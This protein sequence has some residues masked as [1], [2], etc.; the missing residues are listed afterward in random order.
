[1]NV[2]ITGHRSGLGLALSN[3]LTHQ[4]HKVRGF[5]KSTG[6]NILSYESRLPMIAETKFTY[7][8]VFNNAYA[9]P[10]QIDVLYDY[11]EVWQ[12]K[13]DKTIV[14]ISCTLDQDPN[15]VPIDKDRYYAFKRG[16]E[17]GSKHLAA[18]AGLNGPLILCPRIELMDTL[19]SRFVDGDKH[20]PSDVAR[21]LWK[22]V[23]A[24]IAQRMMERQQAAK[25]AEL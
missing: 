12:G 22:G 20:L 11:W 18:Q 25:A 14:N 10:G 17:E 13:P 24:K 2:V 6:V 7:D 1:M 8:I 3:L 15:G 21:M 19:S 9:G 5:S 23:Q 4:G 16:L